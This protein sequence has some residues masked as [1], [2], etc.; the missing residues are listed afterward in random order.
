MKTHQNIVLYIVILA[1]MLSSCLITDQIGSVSVEVM[2]PASFTI[3]N[4][5]R[6]VAFYKRDKYQSD[7]FKIGYISA[8][9]VFI[10][11]TV[12]YSQLSNKCVDA[13]ADYI[14][15]NG[16]FEQ[17]NNYRD[18]LNIFIY[19]PS[20]DDSR[21]ILTEKS[22]ADLLIFLDYFH[23]NSAI[24]DLGTETLFHTTPLMRWTISLKNDSNVYYLDQKDT[25][26]FNSQN[27]N[28]SDLK[29]K[30][31]GKILE[32]CAGIEGEY[33]GSKL[34]P[35]WITV[36]RMYYKSNNTE[37]LK[38]E[39]LALKNN[40]REAAEIWNTM[41]KSKNAHIAA[42]AKFNM[43]LACEME[44]HPDLAIEWIT[45]SYIEFNENDEQHKANCQRYIN[46]LALRKK[47]IAKLEKQVF[48]L[49]ANDSLLTTPQ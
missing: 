33:F 11:T 28:L 34:L 7:T 4:T 14:S 6:T 3:P 1:G 44:G 18:S 8:E 25:L 26:Q 2:K 32:K 16:N 17:V 40:W 22:K 15:K 37:M 48:V 27:F 39:K 23:L 13:A 43:A 12:R 29:N 24:L 35:S 46:V 20:S 47:E 38:A 42:K 10:D 21:R 41:A 36:S 9:K 49:K 45:K 31:S 19:G 5:V 30:R